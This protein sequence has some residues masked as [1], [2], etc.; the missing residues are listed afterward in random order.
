MSL[1]INKVIVLGNVGSDPDVRILPSGM[2]IATFSVATT[3]RT[4]DNRGDYHERTEWV[5]LIAFDRRAEVVR[6]YVH[7]GTKVYVEGKL[8]T[9]SWNDKASG[10]KRY[11]TNVL[12][13][14]LLLLSFPNGERHG[15]EN[16]DAARASDN[17]D[18]NSLAG[19][20]LAD[21]I[22]F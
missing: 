3:E 6:D 9:D 7:K 22:P 13:K 17:E 8:H 2:A 19:V 16:R 11:R 21:D 1:G 18:A 10:E 12:L 4:K 20:G 14:E 15:S 5:R